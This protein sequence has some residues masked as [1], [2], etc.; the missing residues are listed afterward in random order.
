MTEEDIQW[1]MEQ[2]GMLKTVDGQ[3]YVCTDENLLASIYKKG[4]REGKPVVRENIHWIPFRI[5]WEGQ[6]L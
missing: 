4:G 3:P 1:T 6:P 2:V 5:K